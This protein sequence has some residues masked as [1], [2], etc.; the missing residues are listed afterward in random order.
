MLR[1]FSLFVCL[2]ASIYALSAAAADQLVTPPAPEAGHAPQVA[3]P[4]TESSCGP[5]CSQKCVTQGCASLGLCDPCAH[6]G[7]GICHH[8][9]FSCLR[10][11]HSTCDMYPH[12]PYFPE[13]HGYYY[14]RP[15]NFAHI[16]QHTEE[17][18]MILGTPWHPYSVSIF[19]TIP[20]PVGPE[21]PGTEPSEEFQLQPIHRDLPKLEDLLN[22]GG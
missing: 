20:I 1:P 18:V 5:I 7:F 10:K 21:M 12:Y 6:H 15:Y 17:A 8:S 13:H 16:F 4:A 14:F 22:A 9:C 3:A 19:D 2:G 11:L